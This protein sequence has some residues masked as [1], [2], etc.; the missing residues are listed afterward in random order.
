MFK[1]VYANVVAAADAA[2]AAECSIAR[3]VHESSSTEQL[4][5][6]PAARFFSLMTSM[7]STGEA[8]GDFFDMSSRFRGA[9]CCILQSQ[10]GWITQGLPL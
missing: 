7:V 2:A 9:R 8:V 3:S 1:L 4:K 6:T 5:A 10:R